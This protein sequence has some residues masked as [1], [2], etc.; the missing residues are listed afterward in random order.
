MNTNASSCEIAVVGGGIVGTATACALAQAGFDVQ[1]IER[2]SAPA[3][4]DPAQVDPRVYAISAGSADFLDA[5][6]V[7]EA[8]RRTRAEPIQRMQVWDR[9]ATQPLRF[10]AADAGAPSLGWIVEHRL[11]ARTLWSAL[12]PARVHTGL[13]VRDVRFDDET[14]AELRLSDGRTLHARLAIGAEGADSALRDAAGIDTA[15]WSYASTA[16]VCHIRSEH[17]HRGAALQR[18]LPSGPVALLP[19]SDGRRSLV[20]STTDADA[21]ELLALSDTDFAAH[22]QAA[23]QDAAGVLSAPTRRLSF[24]LRLLHARQ[25]V[26]PRCALVGDSAHVI[27]PLAGQGLNLG[28]ADAQCLVAEVT[29]ARRAKR[30]WSAMRT[31]QRYE[32]ARQAENLDMLALTD[33][34][35]RVFALDLP[36]WRAL[37]SFG[38]RTVDRMDVV[39]TGLASRAARSA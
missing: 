30:D 13:D 3:S 7:W 10:D 25:Y 6:G 24:P 1:L 8:V 31:L 4:F 26:A 20:W 39:K 18:F 23:V 2:G 19:L 36:G 33:A 34:L 5:L 9:D 11:L 14:G 17:P 38:L 29:T 12:P 15:G 16:V 32:R 21:R 37:L 28:L 35:G 27:H 22:L